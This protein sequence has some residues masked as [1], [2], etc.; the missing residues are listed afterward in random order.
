M[1]DE[2]QPT[3]LVRDPATA[4]SYGALA[5]TVGLTGAFAIAPALAL[6]CGAL[7][8]AS[9]LVGRQTSARRTGGRPPYGTQTE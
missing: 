3:A 6:A 1:P 5:D 2:P 4:I 8:L 9:T 7:L